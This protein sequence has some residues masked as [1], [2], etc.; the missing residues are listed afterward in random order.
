MIYPFHPAGLY[1]GGVATKDN[2]V[3]LT[4]AGGQRLAEA[5]LPAGN[6][7]EMLYRQGR[8]FDLFPGAAWRVGPA[9]Q[10]EADLYLIRLERMR[11]VEG[12]VT[13]RAGGQAPDGPYAWTADIFYGLR[14]IWEFSLPLPAKAAANDIGL[15]LNLA[16][17]IHRLIDDP[18]ARGRPGLADTIA[19]ENEFTA[20]DFAAAGNAYRL[21]WLDRTCNIVFPALL[22]DGEK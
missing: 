11:Q 7:P 15:R 18:P 9:W 20:D 3:T 14:H 22:L 6:S 12:S 1:P 5:P 16:R 2:I 8:L 21:R 13:F 4:A 17:A 19:L 10:G